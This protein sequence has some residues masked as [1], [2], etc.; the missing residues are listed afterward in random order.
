MFRNTLFWVVY[1][2]SR[3]LAYHIIQSGARIQPWSW[4]EKEYLPQQIRYL[5]RPTL[6]DQVAT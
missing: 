5:P 3:D 6:T 4:V 2:N 1:N